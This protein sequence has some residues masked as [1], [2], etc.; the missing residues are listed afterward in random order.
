MTHSTTA[1]AQHFEQKDFAH[2]LPKMHFRDQFVAINVGNISPTLFRKKIND[3]RFLGKKETAS[4]VLLTM[5]ARV[6][7]LYYASVQ[8]SCTRQILKEKFSQNF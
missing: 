5:A 6:C 1:H 2:G 4:N 3:F 8:V 7:A